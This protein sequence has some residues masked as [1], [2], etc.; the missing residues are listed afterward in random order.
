MNTYSATVKLMVNGRSLYAS[1]EVRAMNSSEARWLLWAQ[2]GFHSIV[3][4]PIYKTSPN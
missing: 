2:F 3:A 4:G 1:T